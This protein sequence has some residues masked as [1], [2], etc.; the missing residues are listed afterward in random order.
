MTHE[1][2]TT[3]VPAASKDAGTRPFGPSVVNGLLF[4]AIVGGGPA[5]MVAGASVGDVFRAL[6]VFPVAVLLAEWLM[7]RARGETTADVARRELPRM[8]R[9]GFTVGAVLAAVAWLAVF[10]GVL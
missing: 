5:T 4:T 9:G 2:R 1:V 3:A 10:G 7:H 8:D 6:L